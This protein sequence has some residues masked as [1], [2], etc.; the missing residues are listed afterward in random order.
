MSV[1]KAIDRDLKEAMRRQDAPVL[2]V[3]RMVKA[4]LHNEAIARK[5]QELPDEVT[6]PV[7]RTQAKKRREAALAFRQ[8]DRAVMADQE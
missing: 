2:S 1:E 3:L 5:L 4:A 8:G 7:L 6:L